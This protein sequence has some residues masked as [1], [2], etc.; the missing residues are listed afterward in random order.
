MQAAVLTACLLCRVLQRRRLVP[1][2]L[3]ARWL[4]QRRQLQP[5]LSTLFKPHEWQA[6]AVAP[7]LLVTPAWPT[8][9]QVA[10]GLL[11]W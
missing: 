9:Q 1:K 5:Q 7:Q 4:A 6:G 11:W 10:E 2:Q 8:P 3:D